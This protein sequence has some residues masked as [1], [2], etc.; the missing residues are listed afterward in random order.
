MKTVHHLRQEHYVF[1]IMQ[2]RIK[3]PFSCSAR[4]WKRPD[5]LCYGMKRNSLLNKRSI[6]PK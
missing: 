6:S 2:R 3:H 4:H 1:S 5:F